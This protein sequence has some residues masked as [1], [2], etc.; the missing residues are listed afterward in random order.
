MSC[1]LTWVSFFQQ[2]LLQQQQPAAVAI[3]TVSHY[4]NSYSL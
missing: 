2:L 3:S 4:R 1:A